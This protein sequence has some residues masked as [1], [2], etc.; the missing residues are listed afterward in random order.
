[1]ASYRV[2]VVKTADS[3]F[4]T[5]ASYDAVEVPLNEAQVQGT[6]GWVYGSLLALVVLVAVRA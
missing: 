6:Y 1:V 3:L 2:R 5:D 4:S